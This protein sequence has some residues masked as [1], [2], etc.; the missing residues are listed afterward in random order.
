MSGFLRPLISRRTFDFTGISNPSI[1]SAIALRSVDVANAK[2]AELC[3][4][5]HANTNPQTGNKVRVVAKPVSLTREEPNA[6]FLADEVGN[7][8]IGTD[9]DY[10]PG[11]LL[12]DAFTKPF[13]GAIQLSVEGFKSAAIDDTLMV[14]ISVDLVMRD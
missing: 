14:T 3:V 6:D 13:G 11:T 2:S 7:V 10:P 8:D 1:V 4:R 9:G 5:V 12:I